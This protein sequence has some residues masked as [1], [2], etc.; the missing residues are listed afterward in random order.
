MRLEI[1]VL[2]AFGLDLLLGDPRWLPHPVRWIGRLALAL[3]TPLRRAL[4]N[5]YAAG[6]AAVLVV[7]GATGLS[8]F[9]LLAAARELGPWGGDAAS[10]VLLYTCLAGR[11][12]ARH[13]QRVHRALADGDLGEARRRVAMLVGRDTERLDEP[14]VAR[15][16]VES[17]AENLVDGVTA[18]I[19][20]ALIGGPVGALIYKAVNT[21][22][23]TFGYKNE[24]YLRF[25]W[26]S[27]RL[28]DCVNYLPAR[29]TAPLVA[30][31]AALLRLRPLAAW[32]TLRRDGRKHPS[33]N[34]GLSEAAVA[35]ALGV[36]LG[37]LN[38]YFGQPSERPPMGD[39][40]QT[41]R[42][43]HILAANRLM[44]TTSALALLVFAGIRLTLI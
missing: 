38:Y 24:R 30:A 8:A 41:L 18:P 6:C 12:L 39:P 1:Q 19:F 20:F 4:R 14:G 44:L 11:D 13:A 33:P 22:D 23:S 25:G 36:Q 10:I 27:A 15:A 7:L 21:L 34:S 31:A 32:R 42:R 26:A 5:D 29:L 2:A 9:A 43:G 40:G 28:D 16:A 17:V 37:G 3:E 35:G